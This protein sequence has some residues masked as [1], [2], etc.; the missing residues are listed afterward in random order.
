MLITLQF[1]VFIE[2]QLK[3]RSYDEIKQFLI[4]FYKFILTHTIMRDPIWFHKLHFLLFP[5]FE[6][7]ISTRPFIKFSLLIRQNTTKNYFLSNRHECKRIF[8][9]VTIITLKNLEICMYVDVH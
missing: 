7:E 9:L 8:T 6:H 3:F 2:D 5:R 1:L 4:E